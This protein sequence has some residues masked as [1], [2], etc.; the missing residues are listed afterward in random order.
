MRIDEKKAKE[1]DE[2]SRKAA[3]LAAKTAEDRKG[4]DVVLY[5]VGSSSAIAD[6]YLICTGFSEPHIK[7]VSN[8]IGKALKEELDMMPKH[9]EGVATSQWIVMDYPNLLIHI[10]HPESREKYRLEELWEEGKQIYPEVA[11]EAPEST[12]E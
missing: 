9:T 3:F 8:H 1:F 4:E 11:T 5:D 12:E 2:I 6:Y 7:A 10:F